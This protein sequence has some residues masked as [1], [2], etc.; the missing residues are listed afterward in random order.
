[1]LLVFDLDLTICDN[2]R[3]KRSALERGL[4]PG[5]AL[6]GA[7]RLRNEMVE[8]IVR[9]LR[10]G[11]DVARQV[12]HRF[13]FDED[14]FDLDVPLEGAPEVLEGLAAAGHTL[15]YATGRPLRKTAEAFLTRFRFPR[16]PVYADFVGPGESWKKVRLFR[17]IREREGGAPGIAVGDLVGDALAAREAGLFAVGTLQ[18]TERVHERADLEEVCDALIGH[19][20]EFPA[21]LE[22]V[23]RIGQGEGGRGTL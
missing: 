22:R 18:A 1:M 17:E 16:A 20:R 6:A 13:F 9:D 12:M 14:L 15:Y 11:G 21:L 23:Q 4:G 7:D 5:L 8:N 3:R 10:V 19:I 2:S